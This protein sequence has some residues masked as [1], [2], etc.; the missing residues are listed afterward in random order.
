M[1]ESGMLRSR[2]FALANGMGQTVARAEHYFHLPRRL[3]LV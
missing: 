3:V 2:G 1:F